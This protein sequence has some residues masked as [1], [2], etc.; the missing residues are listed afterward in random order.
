MHHLLFRS[1][2]LY[3]RQFITRRSINSQVISCFILY[4]WYLFKAIK[5]KS[6]VKKYL[7]N[8]YKSY[9]KLNAHQGLSWSQSYGS[10]IYNYLCNQCISPL[11]LWVQIPF[12]RGVLNT[13][14]CDKVCQWVAAGRWF[15]TGISVSSTNKTDH[16][17]ITE[18]LLKV[19]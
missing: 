14:L 7:L 18:M 10:W 19:T 4:F 9:F 2:D 16:Q 5:E 3:I 11:T 6:E 1:I 15:S 13:T 8:H 17:D 12:R